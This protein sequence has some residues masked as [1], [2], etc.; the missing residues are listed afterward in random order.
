MGIAEE[1]LIRCEI[2]AVFAVNS[3]DLL[4][5]EEIERKFASLEHRMVEFIRKYN[6]PKSSGR[7]SIQELFTLCKFV[8]D[9]YKSFLRVKEANPTGEQVSDQELSSMN[10]SI[11]Q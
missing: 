7:V 11:N 3:I 2:G 8:F 1:L 9:F 4:S 5:S 6:P 10:S